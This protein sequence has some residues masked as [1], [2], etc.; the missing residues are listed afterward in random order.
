M[1]QVR[2]GLM[3]MALCGLSAT[4]WA[5]GPRFVGSAVHGNPGAT[6]AWAT[7]N[8]QYFT[9]PGALNAN[10]THAQADAMVAAAAAVW[11]VPSS[12][13]TL[14]QGGE[15]AEHVSGTNSYL[16]GD[17][18]LF[19]ADVLPANEANIPVAI[20][21]DTDGSVTDLLMGSGASTPMS[22]R[23]NAVVGDVDDLGPYDAIHHATLV[24]NGRCVGSAPEQLLQMQ[25]QLARAFGR[26][27]GLAWS[28]T[29]DNV[30][31][32]ATPVNPQQMAFWPL[33]HP[34]DVICGTYTY[35]CMTDPFTL[36]V[37]DVSS[38]ERLYTVPTNNV[39]AGKQA[40]S[41]DSIW[42]Y[43]NPTFPTGQ[44]MAW[45]NY[46]VS[47]THDNVNETWQTTSA[48]S[49]GYFQQG[50]ANP[51][52]QQ[53]PVS[54]GTSDPSQEG[55]LQMRR[56]PVDG[57]STLY[58]VPEPINPLY[59]GEF[60]V[61]M[62]VRPPVT[63]SGHS[64]SMIDW[65]AF[66]WMG[67][68]ISA[69]YATTSD[70]ASTCSPGADGTETA[71]AALSPT[72]WQ[73]G[74][75]CGWG[76]FSWWS[77]SI[78]AGHSWTFEVTATDENGAATLNKVQPVIG[79]WKTADAT[80]TLP[81]VAAVSVPFNSM[82]YGVTQLQMSA[83]SAAR[84]L[85]LTV[86]DQFAA[87]RPDFTYT[88]RLLYAASVAPA[89]IGQAGGSLTITG[90]GF[91][92]GNG[93]TVNGVAATVVSWTATQI[94]A[95]APSMALAGAQLGHAV[96]VAVTDASTG[97]STRI[98]SAL[99]YV[100]TADV[101]VKVSAPAALVSGS[102]AAT[103]FAVRVL[104]PNGTSP[105]AGATV[106]LTVTSGSASLGLCG[107][108]TCTATSDSAGLV[109]TS[110]TGVSAGT[111]V[112][113]AT[114]LSG[115]ATVQITLTDTDPARFV[116][117]SNG[118]QWAPAGTAGSWTVNLT[119]S[120]GGAPAVGVPVTWNAAGG[121][122][123]SAGNANTSGAGGASVAVSTAGLP[124]GAVSTVTGCVWT[125]VCATWTVYAVDPAQWQITVTTGAG[126]S[127]G[128][129]ETF[130][131][132]VFSVVN[133]AGHVLPGAP[134]TIH[135]RA[136]GWEGPCAASGPCASAP[137]LQATTATV[138]ADGNGAVTVNP[139]EVQGQ[140]QTVEIA[141]STG[142]MG[143]VT[144]TLVVRP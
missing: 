117:V 116:S 4:A 43:G 21:Y 44:G 132:L 84:S 26:V 75:L 54:L 118:T 60:A 93:V 94:V 34:I 25:Y 49:G 72:G 23:Q 138:A 78:A 81:T 16:Q 33:M 52:T 120:Q 66:D 106:R 92:Q 111:S 11:N 141:A 13:L 126:Q 28:Q 144:L 58:M 123:L 37:D 122:S 143:F 109:Q 130:A 105:V 6:I 2:I 88:A 113:T 104:A 99:S 71:P 22:C 100:A 50:L 47:R 131:P 82:A 97:G 30:F 135:Q 134:V 74:L 29:N 57:V 63:P 18:V 140:P 80:G 31:T 38:L 14:S 1:A 129:G 98:S 51:V 55:A 91:R 142:T 87:G 24:L 32:V 110:I 67:D 89:A 17:T 119:A 15:L 12:S 7:N 53:T 65:S 42:L 19:P 139:L 112:V 85:R 41:T 125:T 115:G 114:E 9:D 62:Y 3:V 137:V 68:Q 90:T 76:H 10:V 77:V 70:A 48:V 124:P 56:V 59:S 5:G 96:S 101:L 39:P 8:L 95:I 136:L 133:G 64:P 20:L 83:S 40:T 128:A 108:G 69:F 73:A 103:P 27:L 45:V 36:R 107:G 46:A 86:A 79:V 127:L 61:G 102:A 121:L 35:Q